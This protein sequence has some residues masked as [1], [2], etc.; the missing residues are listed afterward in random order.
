MVCMIRRRFLYAQTRLDVRGV[1]SGSLR[2]SF[3][4]TGG[5]GF[6]QGTLRE[7]QETPTDHGDQVINIMT[8][9]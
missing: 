8:G 1:V 6:E 3:G 5:A 4:A 7:V 9:G 2:G